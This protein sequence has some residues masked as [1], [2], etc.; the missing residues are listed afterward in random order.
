MYNLSHNELGAINMNQQKIE[1][2]ELTYHSSVNNHCYKNDCFTVFEN[3]L[4]PEMYDHNFIYIHEL[5]D[6]SQFEEIYLKFKQ[7]NLQRGKEYVN[8]YFAM[9]LLIDE[10]VYSA[11]LQNEDYE[12][13]KIVFME[14]TKSPIQWKSY[15]DIEVVKVNTKELLDE[16]LQLNY[17]ED[18]IMSKVFAK[19]KRKF[20]QHLYES[21][22]CDFYVAYYQGRAASS[23]EMHINDNVGKLENLFVIDSCRN[24]GVATELMR[25]M[26]THSESL[27]LENFYLATY[28]FDD[29]IKLYH[30]LGF[31]KVAEQENITIFYS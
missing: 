3:T 15:E 30:N 26:V 11:V 10:A 23:G 24:K 7:Q 5:L 8:F 20:N 9:N 6:K 27:G 13:E 17:E 28:Q 12:V 1:K 16:F 14:L 21:G 18:L 4:V 25:K 29:P 22:S 2:L 19:E 31:I